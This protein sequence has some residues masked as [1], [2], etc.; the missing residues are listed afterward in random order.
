MS[1]VTCHMSHI[2]C[3]VSQVSG[4]MR[5]VSGGMTCVIFLGGGG[6]GVL[7]PVNGG[8]VINGVYVV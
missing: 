3:P 4:V 1:H 8:S 5:L 6:V 7:E 2:M